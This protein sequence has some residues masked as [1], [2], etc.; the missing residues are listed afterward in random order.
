M[1]GR[2]SMSYGPGELPVMFGHQGLQVDRVEGADGW[3]NK[4]YNVGPQNVE[5]VYFFS[6]EHAEHTHLL[7]YMKWGVTPKW[8]SKTTRLS[9]FNARYEGIKESKLWTGCVGHRCAV[10]IEGYFEW[11]TEPSKA[12]QPWFIRRKDKE[13][14][15]LA[16]LYNVTPEGNYEFTIITWEAPKQ[17]EWLHPRMPVVLTPGTKEFDSWLGTRSSDWDEVKKLLNIY[18]DD[19]L[20]WFKVKKEVGNVHNDG[21][22]Y[23]EPLKELQGLGN[24]LKQDKAGDEKIV[25]KEEDAEVSTKKEDPELALD[26]ENRTGSFANIKQE[27]TPPRKRPHSS[28]ESPTT[29]SKRQSTLTNFLRK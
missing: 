14:M 13:L 28:P 23:V 15:F 19:Q 3:S 16:G 24:W 11:K 4:R 18:N 5:P 2:Y 17:L 8:A 7:R 27:S 1:C 26:N 9:T 20:E 21:K 6:V 25:K 29:P 22:Q 10:P 12:K